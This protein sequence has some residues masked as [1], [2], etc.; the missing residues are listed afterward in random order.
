[1]L[2]LF[3]LIRDDAGI[4]NVY[5]IAHSMGNQILLEALAHAHN[6]GDGIK[7]SEIIMASPDVPRDVFSQRIGALTLLSGGL[8]L[9]ASSADKALAASHVYSDF[10]RAGDIPAKEG[11]LIAP[12]LDTID[13]TALGDDPFA[14]NHK[15]AGNRS[16]I[17]DIGRLISSPNLTKRLTPGERS[18]QLI[19]MPAHPPP[20]YW[21]YP[22]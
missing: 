8:T 16:V 21:R 1:L 13:V 5:V 15:V 2:Q 12:G 19:A 7:L 20:T 18:P 9:Y 4:T 14:F 10:V 6:A 22:Q 3:H 17:D 11:P